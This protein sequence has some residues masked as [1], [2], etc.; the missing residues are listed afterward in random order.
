MS[1]V[2]LAF[3][4]AGSIRCAAPVIATLATYFGERQMDMGG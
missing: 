4:G 3:I 2:K 1:T